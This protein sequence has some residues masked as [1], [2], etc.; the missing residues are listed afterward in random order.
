MAAAP[1]AGM[2]GMG[3]MQIPLMQ[4]LALAEGIIGNTSSQHTNISR[5]EK[6]LSRQT[7]E[8]PPQPPKYSQA[9]RN[10]KHADPQLEDRLKWQRYKLLE[11]LRRG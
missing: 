5:K 3:P 9:I 11:A 8:S 6:P 4:A 10:E 7:L 1:M 2:P